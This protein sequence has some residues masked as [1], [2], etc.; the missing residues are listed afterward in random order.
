MRDLLTAKRLLLQSGT[1]VDAT[2]IAA[3]SSTKN[4][5]Q[6]RDPEMP[7]TRKGNTWFFGMKLHVGTDPRGLVHSLTAT[8]RAIYGNRAY[9][10]EGLRQAFRRCGVRPRAAARDEAD[11]AEPVVG[12]EHG[13]GLYALPAGQSL[14]G[15]IPIAP[16]GS[17]VSPLATC[18][19][20]SLARDAR[21]APPSGAERFPNGH[22]HARAPGVRPHHDLCRASLDIHT[23]ATG[24]V[25]SSFIWPIWR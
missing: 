16:G 24:R 17:D 21:R 10:S 18:A 20:G 13:A 7:Q 25:D 3:P 8:E 5:A 9:W 4:A 14:Y 19:V 12:K 23:T 11:L 15:A 22:S 2:I 6:A 1:I